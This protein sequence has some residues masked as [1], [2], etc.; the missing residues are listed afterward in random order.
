MI[1]IRQS[2]AKKNPA[3][4]E[5][6]PAVPAK[7]RSRTAASRAA[8]APEAAPD[9]GNLAWL[10]AKAEEV[11][12]KETKPL[13][14]LILLGGSGAAHVRLRM[15]QAH[16]RNDM[17]PS[18]WSH[19]V[20]STD[21]QL[22]KGKDIAVAPPIAWNF[23]P[24]SNGLINVNLKNFDSVDEFPNVALIGVPVDPKAVDEAAENFWKLRRNGLDAVDMM[25]RWLGFLW[26][27]DGAHNPLTEGIGMPS[28]AMVEFVLN[29]VSY[30]ITP[31]LTSR[32]SCPEA[33]WQSARWWNDYHLSET[34]SGLTG[35]YLVRNRIVPERK[36]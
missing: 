32:S 10:H 14:W 33:I 15:A 31:A 19:V 36:E 34:K 7:R 28:A 26:G 23:P 21:P 12:A 11:R 4:D 22:R 27:V 18:N 29:A 35:G 17:T 16:L 25:V 9:P 2:S 6:S 3:F 24:A 20:L 1:A 5:P 30:D 13:T 8:R